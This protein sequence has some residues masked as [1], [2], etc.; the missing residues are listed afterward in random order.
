MKF[1]TFVPAVL[2]VA[3]FFGAAHAGPVAVSAD[4]KTAAKVILETELK[5]VADVCVDLTAKAC[6]DVNIDLAATA[7]ILGGLVQI[8]VDAKTRTS[9]RAEAQA[10]IKAKANIDATTKDVIADVN[11]NLGLEIEAIILDV[12]PSGL[13]KDILKKG[14]LNK[15][16]AKVNAHIHAKI[17]AK[18]RAQVEAHARLRL[19]ATI[20]KLTV[21]TPLAKASIKA[22]VWVASNIDVKLCVGIF[23]KVFVHLKAKAIIIANIAVAL[24]A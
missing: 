24:K 10:K 3:S 8:E 21:H 6:L 15:I 18:V 1:T 5:V 23:A 11:A 9:I 19:T 7:D 4:V 2:A 22:R 13:K 17:T 20:E 16:I 12:C 14:N